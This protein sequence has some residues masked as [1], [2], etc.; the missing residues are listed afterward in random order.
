MRRR[1][2]RRNWNKTQEGEL[3]CCFGTQWENH[4]NDRGCARCEVETQ[5]R[6]PTPQHDERHENGTEKEGRRH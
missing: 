5:G 2:L 3:A 6:T 4:W 1:S